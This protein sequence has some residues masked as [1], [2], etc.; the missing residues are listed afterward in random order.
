MHVR[1]IYESGRDSGTKE[2]VEKTKLL[3][4]LKW[5]GNDRK[6]LIRFTRYMEALVA[7]H[8]YFGGKE[9]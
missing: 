4:Y 6:R 9:T 3:E 7:F 8:R 1:V 2:F 5:I